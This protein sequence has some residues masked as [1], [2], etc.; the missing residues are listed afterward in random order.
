MRPIYRRF[1]EEIAADDVLVP[2]E[3]SPTDELRRLR[4]IGWPDLDALLAI[5]EDLGKVIVVEYL[6]TDVLEKLLVSP[7][8]G[9]R[10]R[11]MCNTMDRM[12]VGATTVAF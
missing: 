6:C 8:A 11:Y 5:H 3:E 12:D 9:A 10:R 4:D 1:C 2:L 7:P